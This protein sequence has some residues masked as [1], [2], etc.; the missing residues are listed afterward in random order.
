MITTNYSCRNKCTG[1]C[2]SVRGISVGI[3]RRVADLWGF[4]WGSKKPLTSLADQSQDIQV[5]RPLQA[6]DHSSSNPAWPGQLSR[7]R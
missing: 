3:S 1:V 4:W 6:R 7:E 2:R 5:L